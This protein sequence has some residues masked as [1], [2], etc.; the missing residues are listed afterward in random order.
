MKEKAYKDIEN[1]KLKALDEMKS[2]IGDLALLAA[3]KIVKKEIDQ[4][5]LDDYVNEFIEKVNEA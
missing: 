5:V 3:T 2:E 4:N 1:Q